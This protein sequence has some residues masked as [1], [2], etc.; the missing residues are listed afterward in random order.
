MQQGFKRT[1]WTN[2][3]FPGGFEYDTTVQTPGQSYKSDDAYHITNGTRSNSLKYIVGTGSNGEAVNS[4]GGNNMCIYLLR[5]ADVLLIYAEGKLGTNAST[6]D[7]TALAAF[8]AVHM[9]AGLPAVSSLTKDMIM[10]ERRVEFAFEGDY[11]FDVQRQGFA[12]AQQ[13]INNQERGTIN[14]D[15]T[16]AHVSAA[17][18]AAS[19]LYLP[20]PNDEVVADPQ[21]NQP[22]VAYYK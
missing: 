9:R 17:F 21:L 4:Q 2:S 20:I 6:S 14:G 15:G 3:L 5:Y 10:H 1:D 7:A 18:N 8:N 19:Q 16:I 11:W 22:A 12:K 13:I